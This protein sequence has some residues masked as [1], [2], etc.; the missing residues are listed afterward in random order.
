MGVIA[1]LSLLALMVPSG[2]PPQAN[3]I[4][5]ATGASL[6]TVA[7]SRPADLG[8]TP[9]SDRVKR[10]ADWSATTQDH[11]AMPFVVVDKQAARLYVF[12]SAARLQAHTAVLIGSALGDHSVPG[13]GQKAI[14]DV[15]PEERTTPA[16]RFN[17]KLG[18]NLTGEDVV[19]VD[20]EA[21]VSMHRVRAHQPAE[22]RLQRLASE[23]I[24]DNRISYGCINVPAAFF[25]AHLLPVF[26][27]QAAAIYVLPDHLSLEQ[28]FGRV[29]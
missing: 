28:V 1:G 8:G 15:L 20:Y 3:A 29:P 25:D 4:P 24:E 16:G 22:R 2:S 21:A 10:I 5:S 11:A 26:S 13:I 23:T 18:S 17:G 7:L 9:V 19:W 14:A 27:A 6:F 12:D